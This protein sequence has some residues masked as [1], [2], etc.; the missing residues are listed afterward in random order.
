MDHIVFS[1][2]STLLI[3]VVHYWIRH[4]YVLPTKGGS[5]MQKTSHSFKFTK[6]YRICPW[7]FCSCKRNKFNRYGRKMNS[8]IV[9]L[10]KCVFLSCVCYTKKFSMFTSSN[11]Y[12]RFLA[13][14]Y[15]YLRCLLLKP[16][17]YVLCFQNPI[18][19]FFASKIW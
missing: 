1:P 14:K 19:T 12:L 10:E 5:L 7:L 8:L 6:I 3:L 13:F 17:I 15:P 4:W 18:V 11:R 2:F 9:K 16:N